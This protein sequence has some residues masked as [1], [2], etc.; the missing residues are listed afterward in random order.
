MREIVFDT[1]TTGLS[2]NDGHRIFEIG[3]VEMVNR[4][5][6]GKTFHHF[7][8]PEQEISAESTRITGITNDQV[9]GKPIFKDILDDLLNFIQN[10]PLVAHNAGFD[11][12]FLN[13]EIERCNYTLPTNSVVDTLQLA[14][15]KIPGA[16]HSLDALCKR[17]NVALHAERDVH[18]A[19]LD[20]QLLAEVYVELTGGLQGS[21]ILD[22]Q[23]KTKERSVMF[24]KASITRSPLVLKPTEE[25]AKNHQTWLSKLPKSLWESS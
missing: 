3:M 7:I 18:G 1:E 21:L 13:Y 19:L 12:S 9:R 4:L 24:Q 17:F 10:D 2:P 11:M 25:E 5:P 8:D 15:K 22:Q 23:K 14:R 16:R 6:T 20:A